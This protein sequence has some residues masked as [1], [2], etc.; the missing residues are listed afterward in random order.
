LKRYEESNC[1]PFLPGDHSIM[2]SETKMSEIYQN[3]PEIGYQAILNLYMHEGNLLWNRYNVMLVANSVMIAIIGILFS[4]IPANKW[5][6]V[7]LIVCGAVLSVF[8]FSLTN[9]G[10]WTCRHYYWAAIDIET[11]FLAHESN[12]FNR[13]VRCPK[14]DNFYLINGKKEILKKEIFKKRFTVKFCALGSIFVFIVIYCTIL[15][16]VVF[17]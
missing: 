13:T 16:K 17:T 14:E 10:F 3:Y 15:L 9:Q 5:L 2:E 12:I 1:N 11:R 4:N 8:W 7:L 6:L